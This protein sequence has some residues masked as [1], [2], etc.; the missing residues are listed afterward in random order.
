MAYEFLNKNPTQKLVGD[1]VVRAISL[2]E[3]ESWDKTYIA[4]SI[5]GFLMKDVFTSNAV[6]GAYLMQ[7]GYT[8]H[9]IS[10]DCPECYD[11]E[12]FVEE[13]PKGTYI[14]CTGSHVVTAIS[15]TFY[16]TWFSGNEIP[17]YYWK[18]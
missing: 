10:N 12:T 9:A 5:L 18:K 4:L 13:H 2:A 3:N 7:Q 16:D 15:G 6:W 1:C 11:I 17:Q 8:R 14:L